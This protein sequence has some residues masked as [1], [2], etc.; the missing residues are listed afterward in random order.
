MPDG[1]L[2]GWSALVDDALVE[3]VCEQPATFYFKSPDGFV[4]NR[5]NRHAGAFWEEH[6][7]HGYTVIQKDSK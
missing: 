1:P 6:Q 5:C 3:I 4:S 2:C 7:R